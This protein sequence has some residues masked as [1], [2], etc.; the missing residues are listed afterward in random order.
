MPDLF[1]LDIAGL[2]ADS[3]ASAGDVRPGTL[4]HKVAGTRGSGDNVLAGTNPT[5][6]THS[7]RGFVETRTPRRAESLVENPIAVVSILGATVSP[8]VEPDVGDVATID[9]DAYTLV[10]LLSAD[11]A[12]ALYEFRGEEA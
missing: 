10:E 11:P 7:F 5:T 4:A 8:M 12:R 3:I 6:T 1:G 9:G 2:V